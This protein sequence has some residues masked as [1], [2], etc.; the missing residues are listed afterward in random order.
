MSTF[1]LQRSY[2]KLYVIIPVL[3]GGSDLHPGGA[4]GHRPDGHP[5]ED[6]R[7][8]PEGDHGEAAS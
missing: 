2:P 7:Q 5:E 6:R 8:R 3:P 1:S 4:G